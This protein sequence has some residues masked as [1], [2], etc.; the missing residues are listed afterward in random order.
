MSLVE[1]V[2]ALIFSLYMGESYQSYIILIIIF[3]FIKI[4]LLRLYLIFYL[5]LI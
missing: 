5:F 3:S 2:V 1:Q 4:E